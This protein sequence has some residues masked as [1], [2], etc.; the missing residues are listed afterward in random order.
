MAGPQCYTASGTPPIDGCTMT[1][2]QAQYPKPDGQHPPQPPPGNSADRYKNNTATASDAVK[3]K[4]P[5]PQAAPPSPLLTSGPITITPE[6]LGEIVDT[7]KIKVVA[8]VVQSLNTTINLASIKTAL[9]EAMLIAQM[10]EET[11]GFIKDTT[12]ETGAESSVVYN[13]DPNVPAAYKVKVSISRRFE[14]YL[15]G[16]QLP[17]WRLAKAAYEKSI[18]PKAAPSANPLQSAL[19][20]LAGNVADPKA[21]PG[22]APA[23]PA[24]VKITNYLPG[25]VEVPYWK[26]WYDMDSPDTRRG[27]I[28]KGFGNTTPGDGLTYI[29]RGYIQLTWRGNYA[30]AGKFLKLDLEKNYTQAADNE[31]AIRVT[32]WFWNRAGCNRKASAD[33]DAAFAAVTKAVNGGTVN[34]PTRKAY[35][36]KVKAALLKRVGAAPAAGA[37]PVTTDPKSAPVP[38]P[39]SK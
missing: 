5:V 17:A 8:T 16:K 21:T 23:H 30:A 1:R 28:A 7:T 34:M 22:K 12:T 26:K 39:A 19:A 33:T 35:Y 20:Q 13:P 2:G 14:R 18:D 4:K 31:T 6:I 38:K 11:G 29:G 3:K 27:A 25:D 15:H 32:A 37:P 36:A 10:A 9:A 24:A